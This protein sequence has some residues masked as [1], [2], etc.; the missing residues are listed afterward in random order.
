MEAS[1]GQGRLL[2]GGGDAFFTTRSK[3]L[4]ALSV[5]Y[6]VPTIYQWHEFAAA[7]GLMSYGASLP[8]AFQICG[9]YAGRII[10]GEKPADLPVQRSSKVELIINLKTAQAL[11]LTVPLP[12]LGLGL[13]HDVATGIERGTLKAQT[14][15]LVGLLGGKFE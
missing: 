1:I 14:V 12:S 9:A 6:A 8:N 10:K 13:V 11:G 7:G 15:S 3:Q 4:G 5:R 2:V